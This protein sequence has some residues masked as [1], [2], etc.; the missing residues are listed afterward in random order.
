MEP[1]FQTVCSFGYLLESFLD[2]QRGKRSRADVAEFATRL[3]TNLLRLHRDLSDGTY[4]HGRYT[5][6]SVNDPKPRLIHKALVRDRVVHHAL[7]RSLSDLF[8]RQFIHD[9]Y[10]SRMD[11]GTHRA[12]DRFRTLARQVA[13]NHT[14]TVWVLQCDIQQFFATIDHGVLKAILN[15]SLVDHQYRWLVGEV[16]DS[17]QTRGKPGVGLPLGNLTSQLFANVYLNQFDQWIKRD[18]K[19]RHYLRYADDFVLLHPSRDAL[20]ALI[21]HIS[22]MLEDRL[23]LT[24]HPRKV[25]ITSLASGVDFLGWVHFPHHRVLRTTTKRRMLARL[26]DD[27][28]E[29]VLASYLGLLSHGN[30]YGLSQQILTMVG[31]DQ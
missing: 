11:K 24:L 8:E 13:T 28:S 19:V 9:S 10:A 30:A 22:S 21:P 7:H 20:T 27:S 16:I 26:V 5:Q 15:R 17:F 4:R 23:H 18:L 6:F 14:Q 1:A 2:F 3:S 12:L 31:S 25:T 29:P